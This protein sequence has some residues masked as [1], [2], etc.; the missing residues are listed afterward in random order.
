MT[1]ENNKMSH[2][3]QESVKTD[4]R[5]P[6]SGNPEQPRI[7]FLDAAKNDPVKAAKSFALKASAQSITARKEVQAGKE[8]IHKAPK[9]DMK[10]YQTAQHI[11][12]KANYAASCA[13]AHAENANKH[14]EQ[15]RVAAVNGNVKK[16]NEEAFATSRAATLATSAAF[17]AHRYVVEAQTIIGIQ[18]VPST[19]VLASVSTVS[20]PLSTV[21]TPISVPTYVP[22]PVLTPVVTEATSVP[23][24]NTYASR[25]VSSTQEETTKRVIQPMIDLANHAIV[26]LNNGYNTESTD[27]LTGKIEDHK[28]F[29]PKEVPL[30]EVTSCAIYIIRGKFI[31]VFRNRELTRVSGSLDKKVVMEE[32]DKVLNDFRDAMKTLT[33]TGE[34]VNIAQFDGYPLWKKIIY[35]LLECYNAYHEKTPI[36]MPEQ[37]KAKFEPRRDT[38]AVPRDTQAVHRGES[39]DVR[40][41]NRVFNGSK[42]ERPRNVVARG[43]QYGDSKRVKHSEIEHFI[44]REFRRLSPQL[45]SIG[46]FN[47]NVGIIGN[48]IHPVVQKDKLNVSEDEYDMIVDGIYRYMKKASEEKFPS[49][50][51]ETKIHLKTYMEQFILELNK[52]CVRIAKISDSDVIEGAKTY[53]KTFLER[54]SMEETIYEKYMR[55]SYPVIGME[56]VKNPFEPF[57]K[58]ARE[59]LKEWNRRH[60]NVQ[61]NEVTKS[62]KHAE[63]RVLHVIEPMKPVMGSVSDTH[64]MRLLSHLFTQEEMKSQPV[65][66]TEMSIAK[67][68]NLY[69]KYFRVMEK[70]VKMD[71]ETE[72]N[73]FNVLRWMK[74]TIEREIQDL[75]AIQ[76]LHILHFYDLIGRSIKSPENVE[77]LYRSVS[78]IAMSNEW[79][80]RVTQ[81]FKA[82]LNKVLY[83]VI[84]TPLFSEEDI[85]YFEDHDMQSILKSYY[86]QTADLV[87]KLMKRV[88]KTYTI[89]V[90][91]A[92]KIPGQINVS[93]ARWN[94]ENRITQPV[95]CNSL[96]T[97]ATENTTTL[98]DS[99]HIMMFFA[100]KH[101]LGKLE[102]EQDDS[103]VYKQKDILLTRSLDM[104]HYRVPSDFVNM[105]PLVMLTTVAWIDT[106]D[107]E[108][109]KDDQIYSGFEDLY[110]KNLN[111]MNQAQT[112]LFRCA[113]VRR[114]KST[115]VPLLV[116]L[117]KA[118][119]EYCANDY[120]SDTYN[121]VRKILGNRIQFFRD[122]ISK[123]ATYCLEQFFPML[124]TLLKDFQMG[125]QYI[126]DFPTKVV[127]ILETIRTEARKTVEF[128]CYTM[129]LTETRY[130]SSGSTIEEVDNPCFQIF[131]DCYIDPPP[132]PI[133]TTSSEEKTNVVTEKQQLRSLLKSA[134]MDT[135]NM[136]RRCAIHYGEHIYN[137]YTREKSRFE[138]SVNYCLFCPKQKT[139]LVY[140]DISLADIHSWITHHY[141]LKIGKDSIT[142]E[143]FHNIIDLWVPYDDVKTF[144]L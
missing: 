4:P 116:E 40:R 9:K 28:R 80:S 56:S 88:S 35:A 7:H 13:A 138:E 131:E 104:F 123:N 24:V 2:D 48:V 52:Y 118:H 142:W 50:K 68:T 103:P 134:V 108:C 61:Y 23:P 111:A 54:L 86:R 36:E 72:D 136:M 87:K 112:E 19:Q 122:V 79:K 100:L 141:H 128:L 46:I 77:E 41:S 129:R 115:I 65:V 29:V 93:G 121:Y 3:K 125:E 127:T 60:V 8:A 106:M 31:K 133:S 105:D 45:D 75:S 1:R 26:L 69:E 22:V 82:E 135:V 14:V 94:Y 130:L 109:N 43:P 30:K 120:G 84:V 12:Q 47:S 97:R 144:T 67:I 44:I 62:S 132:P 78:Q 34:R 137:L 140:K 110:M 107:I 63:T 18:V 66:H 114:L 98:I 74:D 37:L 59:F 119:K 96:L 10:A 6:L 17:D 91:E 53:T 89:S 85:V 124:D 76:T 90:K 113:N 58:N 102:Q 81:R 117:D 92:L 5:A 55:W 139:T 95:Q 101:I 39:N 20:V 83:P 57:L 25:L 70:T 27:Y 33:E 64:I 16:A 42:N 71:L 49:S 38:Q 51:E 15:A 32:R 143:T 126:A 11:L 99:K 73:I 21:L